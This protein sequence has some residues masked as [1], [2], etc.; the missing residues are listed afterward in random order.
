VA[1]AAAALAATAETAA[2]GVIYEHAPPSRS[3]Q[4]LA[5]DIKGVLAEIR[6]QATT[7]SDR[8]VAGVLRAIEQGARNTARPPGDDSAYLTLMARL[9]R[10]H[11]AEEP[12]ILEAPKPAQGLIIP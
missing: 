6:K 12:E 1:E 2:R 8:E 5:S 9:L 4:R 7:I 11:H 10:Q 3:A